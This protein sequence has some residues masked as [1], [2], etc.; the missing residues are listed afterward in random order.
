MLH[1]RRGG[2][3]EAEQQSRELSAES[4]R[5]ERLSRVVGADEAADKP[6]GVASSLPR[7]PRLSDE[8]PS[9][10]LP[11][12]QLVRHGARSQALHAQGVR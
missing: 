1:I 5:G 7:S 11:V 3:P 6:E 10:E 4:K 8:R 2:R 9:Q 12:R